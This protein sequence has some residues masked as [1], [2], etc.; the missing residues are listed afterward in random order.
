MVRT[1]APATFM[2]D[3]NTVSYIV[4]GRS[5]RARLKLE[6]LPADC[7]VCLSAITEAE[8]S[9]G[10][11]KRPV[12]AEFR[13]AV[14]RFLASIDVLAWDRKAARE[15]GAMRVRLEPSGRALANM[16]LMIAAHAASI[17]AVL[18]TC[19]KAFSRISES[20]PTANWAED[21]TP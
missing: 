12:K 1:P 14:E 19:D 6:N 15:Y 2:L 5:A 21:V 18:V 3:T 9:Y 20:L 4:R 11:A 13:L 10:L 7:D 8:I 16:D 17:G